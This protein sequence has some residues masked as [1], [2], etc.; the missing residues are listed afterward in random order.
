[1]GFRVCPRHVTLAVLIFALCPNARAA[2]DAGTD[3]RCHA[4]PPNNQARPATVLTI[5]PHVGPCALTHQALRLGLVD[6][7]YPAIP[8]YDSWTP[9]MGD[10]IPVSDAQLAWLAGDEVLARAIASDMDARGSKVFGGLLAAGLGIATSMVGW[11]L[12]GADHLS[13]QVTL[14]IGLGGLAVAA[15]A[16]LYT[17]QALQSPIDPFLTPTP[18][19]RLTREQAAQLIA[20]V[21]AKYDAALCGQGEGPGPGQPGGPIQP[22]QGSGGPEPRS[23]DGG[24]DAL[25]AR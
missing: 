3:C 2:D 8:V 23:R 21:N 12:Y 22:A 17:L 24:S 20:V 6:E 25:P 19:H 4:G 14:P 18:E 13:P 7:E 15:V 11:T 5:D 1:M 16:I 9:V 10:H